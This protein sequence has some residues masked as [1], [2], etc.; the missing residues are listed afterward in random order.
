MPSTSSGISSEL[1]HIHAL[2]QA[3]AFVHNTPT[4]DNTSD[5]TP[6]DLHPTICSKA[7]SD[8]NLKHNVV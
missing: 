3:T 2:H 6:S 5:Q 7:D 1:Y 4:S 8:N